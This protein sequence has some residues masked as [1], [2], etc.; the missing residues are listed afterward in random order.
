ME[1]GGPNFPLLLPRWLLEERLYKKV[2]SKQEHP[3][4]AFQGNEFGRC[5]RSGCPLA[6]ARARQCLSSLRF[7]CPCP[8]AVP[9]AEC[10]NSAAT[11]PRPCLG[12]LM[13]LDIKMSQ[14]GK[15]PG[16]EA[17]KAMGN[18][19]R[20]YCSTSSDH[21]NLPQKTET[22][23]LGKLQRSGNSHSRNIPKGC[24]PCPRCWHCRQ[25]RGK[26]GGAGHNF[27]TIFPC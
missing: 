14:G 26:L 23:I 20:F 8:L 3:L 7:W 10:P 5:G 25:A 15:H 11:S 16:E 18:G 13:Q 2:F 17:V 1:N 24:C 6:V 19:E 22:Q 4:P 9:P 27:G 21:S 12:P